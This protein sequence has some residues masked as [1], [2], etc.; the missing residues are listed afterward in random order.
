ML[1]IRFEELGPHPRKAMQGHRWLIVH[2]RDLVLAQTALMLSEL[3]DILV[4]VDH[5]GIEY[6]HGLWERATHLC[7]LDQHTNLQQ[8]M[9]ASS[10][11]KFVVGESIDI[12]DE[13][14]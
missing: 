10:I 9:D 7:I 13:L 2:A 14:W 8:I 12:V 3:E 5:R 4:A 11:S 1:Y 6:E